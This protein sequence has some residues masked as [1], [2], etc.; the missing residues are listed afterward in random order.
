MA[1]TGFNLGFYTIL[2]TLQKHKIK[3]FIFSII[4][5]NAISDYYIFVKIKGVNYQGINL[6]IQSL[7]IIFTAS[8]FPS[9]IIK[10]KFLIYFMNI[11]TNYTAGIYYLHIPIHDYLKNYIY[12]IKQGSFLGIALIYMIC[13]IICFI[14]MIF[15][16]K[17]PLKHLFC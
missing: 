7:C 17:T 3:T 9:N 10:Y 13:Y 2:E 8:L 4:I 12:S 6:N 5:Y 16:G 15:L 14:G 1:I 11:I